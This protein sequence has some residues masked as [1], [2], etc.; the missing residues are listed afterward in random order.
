MAAFDNTKYDIAIQPQGYSP[1]GYRVKS[2]QKS[3]FSP[4]IPR[5][6]SGDQSESEFDAVKSLTFQSFEGG[7]FARD[8]D[9]N[10]SQ[11]AIEGLYPVF[12]DGR[13]WQTNHGVQSSSLF[14]TGR[15]IAT[16]SCRTKDYTYIS[17][18][19]TSGAAAQRIYRI[20][21]AGTVTALTLPASLSTGAI[22]V[23]DMLIHENNLLI[24]ASNTTPTGSMYYMPVTSTTVTE[25]TGGSGYFHQMVIWNGILYGTGSGT[26]LNF[27][28]YKYTGDLSTRSFQQLARIPT[29]TSDATADLLVY[30]GRIILTRH[31]GMYAYD[32][33]R[34][35]PIE[36]ASETPN[37]RNFRFPCKLKGYLYYWM[38]DGLYR[39]NGASIEKLYDVNDVGYP[40][41]MITAKNR[42]YAVFA[43][44]ATSGSSRYDKSMGYN[45]AT[46]TSFDARVCAFD[47][48]GMFTY[49][50]MTT[51]TK[52]G[53][54]LVA[55]EGEADKLVYS[56]TDDKLYITTFAD[57]GNYHWI[58]SL[59]ESSVT[60]A[61]SGASSWQIVTPVID[62]KF[63]M[64][65]KALA[66]VELLLDGIP[67]ADDSIQVEYRINGL[68]G[69]STWTPLENIY[70]QSRTKLDCYRDTSTGGLT[71]KRIQLRIRPV[72]TSNTACGIAKIVVRYILMPEYKYEWLLTL[73]CF[74]DDPLQPLMLADGTESTQ[75]VSLLRG[76]I[77]GSRARTQPIGFVDVDQMLLTAA[78]A[79]S[80]VSEIYLDSTQLLKTSGYILIDDEVIAFDSNNVAD[81]YISSLT[82]GRF[83]TAAAAHT[84]GT[85]VFIIY[86]TI[87][88]RI[89]ADRVVVDDRG[90]DFASG[91][92]RASEMTIQ[93]QEI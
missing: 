49:S 26:E 43:N 7:Q 91:K 74:G 3:E 48:K 86:P 54:P 79:S 35:A 38:P 69:S 18:Y 11:Y 39:Y 68:D 16:A 78:I 93:L 1:R 50:R 63:P 9:D 66:S 64:V 80:G 84:V 23:T 36:D 27:I 19:T 15:P 77:Y 31:D 24:T 89:T 92:A 62:A 88:K 59:N 58:L 60:A 87:I 82:R 75:S 44:S 55:G 70:L 85:K 2:Y 40:T 90:T 17:V 71:F 56:P 67:S 53:S 12:G 20:N 83:L 34:L 10:I 28:F 52:S 4:F 30:N 32:G 25:T 42:L 51:Q 72:T 14:G 46:G 33:I 22:K 65:D 41:S 47:G 13:L 61:G 73:N 29:L 37:T 6:G 5:L 57:P 81:G 76:N 8:V 21:S 45:Y